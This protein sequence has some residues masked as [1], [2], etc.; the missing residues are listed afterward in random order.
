MAVEGSEAPPSPRGMAA[1]PAAHAGPAAVLPSR[2]AGI[3]S[4]APGL[5][6]VATSCVEMPSTSEGETPELPLRQAMSARSRVSAVVSRSELRETPEPETV[7]VTCSDTGGAGLALREAPGATRAAVFEAVPE[8]APREAV[9]LLLGGVSGGPEAVD[10]CEL[11]YDALAVVMVGA[12]GEA[13]GS[14]VEVVDADAPPGEGAATLLLGELAGSREVVDDG[15]L[16]VDKLAVAVLEIDAAMEALPV[17]RLLAVA[18]VDAEAPEECETV[19]DSESDGGA[20]VLCARDAVDDAL[21]PVEMLADAGVVSV[22]MRELLRRVLER[23]AVR[24][25]DAPSV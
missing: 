10:D 8:K 13:A 18:V 6:G 1:T 9:P 3:A 11:P 12:A 21:E 14:A 4:S 22:A 25:A 20:E 24:D 23:V 19:D 5:D 15:E 16:P 7:S 2:P 17:D